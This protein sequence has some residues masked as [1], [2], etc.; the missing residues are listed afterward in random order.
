MLTASSRTHDQRQQ[1]HTAVHN[2]LQ[3]EEPNTLFWLLK[4]PGRD[5]HAKSP[6][7]WSHGPRL[8]VR[9]LSVQSSDSS[10]HLPHTPV[11]TVLWRW[12]GQREGSLRIASH[13]LARFSQCLKGIRNRVMAQATSR[14]FLWSLLMQT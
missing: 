14:L 12:G 5:T 9:V 11:T 3:P 8:R 6:E 13:C 1:P 2:Y 4:V 7:G 10:T